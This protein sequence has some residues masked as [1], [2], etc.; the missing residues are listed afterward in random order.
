MLFMNKRDGSL[1]L[2]VNYRELNKVTVKNRCPLP[3]IDDLFDQLQG[4]Y[5][6]SKI[7]LRSGY[8]QLKVKTEDVGKTAFR[9]R[10]RHFEFLVMPFGLTNAPTAF[11]DLMNGVFQPYLDQ[12]VVVF[13]DDILIY[14]KSHEDHEGHLRILL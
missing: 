6:F 7:D 11:I 13:I 3:W 5:I 4:S 2:C 1:R 14:S 10:Y 8:H 12:F 9:T